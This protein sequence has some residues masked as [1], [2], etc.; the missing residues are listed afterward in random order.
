VIRI[1]ATL[2]DGHFALAV[3]GHEEHAEG[4]RVCAA[5]SALTQ[6]TLLGL[7]QIAHVHP[8]IVSIQIT[9]M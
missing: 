1:V 7:E 2:A 9:E 3:D 4:G 5:V 8:D 6:T